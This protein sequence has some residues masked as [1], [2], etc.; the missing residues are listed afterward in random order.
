ML[1]PDTSGLNKW[2]L[3]IFSLQVVQ[4]AVCLVLLLLI[5]LGSFKI[6]RNIEFATSTPQDFFQD[7]ISARQLLAGEDIYPDLQPFRDTMFPGVQ[8]PIDVNAHP[9][10]SVLLALPI[11]LWPYGVASL[12]WELTGMLS[13]GLMW[14]LIYRGCGLRPVRYRDWLVLIFAVVSFPTLLSSLVLV[15]M[16]PYISLL[17]VATWYYYRRS[18]RTLAGVLLGLATVIKLYP[19]LL[20]GV[21]LLRR[22][23]RSTLI[24][25]ATVAGVILLTLP[26][27]GMN[28][29]ERY[30]TVLPRVSWW[31]G[32]PG[33]LSLLGFFT[34]AHRLFS[35][36]TSTSLLPSLTAAL[37]ALV[38]GVIVLRG[39]LLR[40]RADGQSGSV[41]WTHSFDI[42]YTCAILLLLVGEPITWTHYCAPAILAWFVVAGSARVRGQRAGIRWGFLLA[43]AVA[44]LMGPLLLSVGFRVMRRSIGLDID[45][46]LVLNFF[47]WPLYSGAL[48]V[49]LL[50]AIHELYLGAEKTTA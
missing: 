39:G 32:E 21:F 22:D 34:G 17:L 45:E 27:L 20:I 33:N 48:I 41:S 5:A 8:D 1:P 43:I 50:L 13:Y 46:S 6:V 23:W 35:G 38:C 29:Y 44:V 3:Q 36:G 7:Y 47:T 16:S 18:R 49:L 30:L 15:T 2:L 26:A 12:I 19:F 25:L 24:V 31:S 14:L 4:G 40:L 42:L 9:P 11:A 10:P 37:T 28:A